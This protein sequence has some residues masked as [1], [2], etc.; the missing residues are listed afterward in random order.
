M[1]QNNK[2]STIMKTNFERIAHLKELGVWEE[3]VMPL[4]AKHYTDERYFNV[5]SFL[6]EN[7]PDKKYGYVPKLLKNEKFLQTFGNQYDEKQ[8][9]KIIHEMEKSIP[10]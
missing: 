1:P 3:D 6:K 4:A 2:N 9:Y 8:I 10:K 5:Y 7:E